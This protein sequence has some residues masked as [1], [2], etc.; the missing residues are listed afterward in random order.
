MVLQLPLATA[1]ID[2]PQRKV[3]ARF[4]DLAYI[5][6]VRSIVDNTRFPSMR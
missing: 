3:K 2:Q 5:I 6:P 1:S 4:L